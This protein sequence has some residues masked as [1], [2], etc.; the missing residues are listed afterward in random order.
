MSDTDAD[1]SQ[2]VAGLINEL[3]RRYRHPIGREFTNREVVEGIEKV[4]G[5]RLIE[6]SYLSKLRAGVVK[7]P[8]ITTIEALCSFFPVEPEYFFPEITALRQQQGQPGGQQ[9]AFYRA[10]QS[11][12]VDPHVLREQLKRLLDALGQLE[13]QHSHKREEE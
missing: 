12:G 7:T 6:V 4:V 1:K 10:L 3:F 8:G 11:S 5:R 2:K 9:V 13:E